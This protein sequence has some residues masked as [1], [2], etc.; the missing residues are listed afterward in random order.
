[1][2]LLVVE[3]PG[4]IKKLRSFLG[5]DWKIL[6]SVGHVCDL[7]QKKLGIEF[8]GD[9]VKVQ[10]VVNDAKR[11]SIDDIIA[12]SKIADEIYLATDP[13]REGEAIAY[14]VGMLVGK[15][16]WKKIK[17][18]SFNEISENA[19]KA[20]IGAP[21]RVDSDLVYAQQA[22]RVVDR[23]VGYRVSPL[24]WQQK[25]VGS[26]AG[27]VQSVAVRLVVE[28]EREI[29]AFVPQEYWH[30]DAF[31]SAL[32]SVEPSF[33]ARLVSWKGKQVVSNVEE[34]KSGQQV[35][36]ATEALADEVINHA[37][38]REWV[39]AKKETKVQKRKAPAPFITSTLQ[40][41][42]NSLRKWDASKTMKVAQSLYEQGVITYMRTDSPS[43]SPEA[44]QA[45]RDFVLS[46]FGEKYLP[47]ESKTFK[48]KDKR[49]QEAHECIRPV[50][51][52]KS[53]SSIGLS[54]DEAWLYD[55]IRNQVLASQMSDS[56]WSVGVLEVKSGDAV[57]ALK[58]KQL[59]FDGWMK[60]LGNDNST[61]KA[62]KGKPEK[63][64]QG[65]NEKDDAPLLPPLEIGDS[66]Q[67]EKLTK[68]QNFTK[69]PPRF[70]VA[71][72]IKALEARSIGRP[73]TYAAILDTIKRRDYVRDLD[74]ALAPTEIGERL[75]MF[76]MEK[77]D[78][79]FMDFE[80]TSRMEDELDKIAAGE[81]KWEAI[82]REFSQTLDRQLGAVQ[83]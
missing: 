3:S 1:V 53:V 18:V 40:Q 37:D 8:I 57:F 64:G 81:A 28:K 33:K 75:V 58:G 17:R 71:T 5:R 12:A 2:K 62:V 68:S 30:I 47:A 15:S 74:G 35:V 44:Q 22:R 41:S 4:K 55:R 42:A 70:T 43:F 61:A 49:S 38:A 14:H 20:A 54:G 10:F 78:K 26:S 60:V 72:L 24:L 79:G 6:A 7:P 63:K 25:N 80:F 16:E 83:K 66:L 23:L 65:S 21:R 50:D 76:L 31:L 19:L 32:D 69:P 73:S 39:V 48:P 77:F 82:V 59:I 67:C 52:G 46:N 56:E 29:R 36:I 45:I 51:I 13:D 34:N 11:R 27:R 9:K